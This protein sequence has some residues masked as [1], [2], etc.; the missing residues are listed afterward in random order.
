MLSRICEFTRPIVIYCMWTVRMISN[1]WINPECSF[2]IR[3]S[4]VNSHKIIKSNQTAP[5]LFTK[6]E[7]IF[8]Y[9]TLSLPLSLSLCL[10]LFLSLSSNGFELELFPTTIRLLYKYNLLSSE[11]RVS[12]A[13]A[14]AEQT[15]WLY[16]IGKWGREKKIESRRDFNEL[17]EIHFFFSI[18]VC[19]FVIISVSVTDCSWLPMPRPFNS[20]F[21]ANGCWENGGKYKKKYYNFSWIFF[22]QTANNK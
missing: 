1:T 5:R 10:P 13:A 3:E 18:F 2:T 17:F 6:A 7:N 12:S 20:K 21:N 19:A 4:H 16:G 11:Q 14:A 15:R 9:G 8:I 22:R